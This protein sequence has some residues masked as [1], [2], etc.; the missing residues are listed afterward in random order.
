MTRAS[1]SRRKIIAA[2]LIVPA[3]FFGA[4]APSN[5]I[6]MAFIGTG[7]NGYGWMPPFLKDKRV[8]VVAV[9]DV[10]RESAGYWDGTVRG[11]EPGRR[12][13]NQHYGNED[14]KAYE[15]YQEVLQRR[16]IDA[17]YIGT[18]DHWHALQAI[19]AARAGKHILC[20]KP[21]ATSVAEGRAMVDAVTKSRVV[22]QTGSQQ[23]SCWSF[24]RARDLVRAGRIGRVHMVR[25]GLPG[26]TP[27]FGKTASETAPRPVPDGFLYDRWLGPAPAAP[28]C[29]ARVGV[30]FRWIRDYSGGQITDWGAHNI[31]SAQWILD[32]AATGPSRILNAHG[33][34]ARHPIY[35]TATDFYFECHYPDGL[36]YRVSSDERQ[37]VRLVGT[38]GWIY[39]NRRRVEASFPL[40]QE[41]LS[42]EQRASQPDEVEKHCQ[43]F[44]QA[45][46]GKEQPVAPIEEAHRSIS[47]A[48]LANISLLVGRDLSWDPDTEKI[49]NDSSASALLSREYRAPYR[50]P[51]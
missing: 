11:R 14:C 33:R 3:T 45:I 5:R 47:I 23:R 18:P 39:V 36:H 42:P 9:C 51:A 21:L 41:E 15:D 43:N 44:V 50:L 31:D 13:V 7:N 48:H 28:Y 4:Q 16:D 1:F 30:N 25:I 35:N 8:Q 22:W 32:R 20:Q 46:L 29:P 2:P 38:D 12:L 26:G 34:W 37:G 17:V 40:E 24:L 6:T 49:L 19:D 10:N 27:D